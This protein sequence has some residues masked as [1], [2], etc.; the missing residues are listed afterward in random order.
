MDAILHLFY[1]VVK[2][3]LITIINIV[4]NDKLLIRIS[5]WIPTS[6]YSRQSFE[7]NRTVIRGGIVI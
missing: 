7:N 5:N 6:K 4:I 2:P 1:I 3:I